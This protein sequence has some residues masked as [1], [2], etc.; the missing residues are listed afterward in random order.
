MSHRY[1]AEE[2]TAADWAAQRI[3]VRGP[4][5][6]H[7]FTV[8]RVRLG[9]QLEIGDGAGRVGSGPVVE[10]SAE[11]VVIAIERELLEEPP[12]P[13]IWLAQA[14]AK[15]DRDELAVQ[16]ATELGVVGVIP[17]QAERSVVQWRAEKRAR[18]VE[19]WRSIVREATKQ[20]LR[21]WLPAVAEPVAGLALAAHPILQGAL[22]LVLEPEAQQ[23]LGRLAP[24]LLH[25]AE[26]IVLVVGPE[27]GIAP[28]E[29][30]ALTAAGATEVRLGGS[31][32]RTSTAGPAALA[33]LHTL[34]G[35]W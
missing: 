26:R 14:L 22:V 31:V 12:Q 2:L 23:P 24:E 28:A 25:D 19:R 16:A 35:A 30:A 11:Q 29:R 6:R 34:L 17:W 3:S 27:G 33:A 4:E 13:A 18:G 5:A 7:A 1:L 10:A 15:G 21:A 9:E 20:A 8:G 32:L